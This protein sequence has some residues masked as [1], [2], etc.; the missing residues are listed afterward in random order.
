MKN[1]TYNR[2]RNYSNNRNRSYSNNQNQ[3]YNN[4][5]RDCSNNRSNQQRSNYN[6]YQN[7]SQNR[8]S[9]YNN[10]Q[11]NYSQSPYRNNTRYPDSQNKYRSNTPKHQ[12]QIN[13][14]QTTDETKSVPL[15]FENT[16]TTKIQLNHINCRK[17]IEKTFLVKLKMI[18]NLLQTNIFFIHK[19][20][21]IT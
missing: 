11:R 8:N 10:R 4:R 12:R 1:S 7:I 9:N 14:V 19:F 5:S 18:M 20:T 3:E 15:G 13:Q 21:K 17:N 16:E 6:Y 2:Y